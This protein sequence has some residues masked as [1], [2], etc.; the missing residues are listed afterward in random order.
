MEYNNLLESVKNLDI[1]DNDEKADAVIKAT[2]GIIASSMD[3]DSAHKLTDNLPEPLTYEKLRGMQEGRTTIN[4]EAFVQEIASQFNISRED[5][6]RV[7]QEV[8][9]STKANLENDQIELIK[10]NVP[11]D[12]KI[13][14]GEN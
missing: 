11:N 13:V 12:I 3:D 1:I 2:L 7:I 6:K 8:Y 10:N 9:N 5:A 4:E 14:L